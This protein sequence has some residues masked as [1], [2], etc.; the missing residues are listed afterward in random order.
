MLFAKNPF[1]SYAM[2]EAL[3]E[4]AFVFSLSGAP[5]GHNICA[6]ELMKTADFPFSQV[7][8]LANFIEVVELLLSDGGG[9]DFVIGGASYE[10]DCRLFSQGTLVRFRPLKERDHMLRL[11]ASL[12]NMPWGIL[13]L[14]VSTKSPTIVYAN[15]GANELMHLDTRRPEEKIAVKALAGFGVDEDLIPQMRGGNVDYYIFEK[16]VSGKTQWFCLHFI[17]YQHG[18][19]YCLLVIE[20]ITE[21]KKRE[22]QSLESQRLESMGQ[23]AGGVAHDFNNILSIIDG[24]ARMGKKSVKENKA[25]E[26][27]F[28]RITQSVDRASAITS[29]LLAFGSHKMTNKNIYDLAEVIEDQKPLLLPLLDASIQLTVKNEKGLFVESDPHILCQ[30]LINL[31][32]NSRDAMPDGGELIVETGRRGTADI[33]F[34]VIDTGRGMSASVQKKMFDPFFTTKEQGKGTGLGLSVV[35]GL[36]K[37]M[38]GE[39]DVVSEEGAGTTITIWLPAISNAKLLKEK[40]ENNLEDLS[41]RGGHRSGCRR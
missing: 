33:F 17:P 13:T 15:R 6:A 28:D 10:Y 30:I 21:E 35:Y 9:Q 32:I 19:S 12:D 41:F 1:K 4:P 40:R 39:I 29:Q 3:E 34:R 27:C 24:Y 26:N 31:C 7:P 8:N 25:A 5:A 20:D 18:R 11:M 38:G 2:V 37:D 23:L 16:K 36:V 14:D 22:S